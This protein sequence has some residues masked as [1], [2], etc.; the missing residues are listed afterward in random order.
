MFRNLLLGTILLAGIIAAPGTAQSLVPID[1][2][3]VTDGHVYLMENVGADLPDDSANSNNGNL[4]GSP[5][6]VAGLNGEALQ[7]NGSSDGAHLPDAATINTSTHQNKTVIAVFNCADVGK[8][9]QQMVYEEG[10]STRGLNI[11]VHEGL[12][13][14]G[15]WNR[16]DYTPNFLGTWLSA[17]IGSNEW[18]VVAA[19]VRGGGAGLEDDKFEMWLDGEL[20]A[21]GPAGELRSR[22]DDNAIGNVQAQTRVDD[23]LVLNAGYWFEGIIDEV[24]ILN[25]ALSESELAAIGFAKTIAQNPVPADEAVDIPR[26]DELA[27]DPGEFARTHDVYLGTTFDD[28]NAADRANPMDLLVSQGQTGT[29]FDPGRLEFGQ[30]YYWRVDE[31]NAAPDNT[32]YTGDVWSFE[33]EPLAY[34]I[35][36][37]TATSTGVSDPDTGPENMVN[38][39]GLNAAGEHSIEASDMWLTVPG[40]APPALQFDFD[41]VYKLHEMRVWNYNVQFELMLGFGVKDVTIEYS[42]NG[43][44]WNVLGDF[45][46]AQGTTMPNYT[47]NTAIDFGGAAVRHVKLTVN[48]GWGPLGQ[49]GLSEVRF[50]YIPVQARE[51]QPAD[52]RTGVA[53]GTTLDWRAGREAEVHEV[54]LSSSGEAVADGT[55]LAD[56][57]SDSAY[58][59]TDLEFGTDYYWRIVEVNEAEAITAWASDIWMFRTEEFAFIEGFESYDDDENRIYDT[60]LDGWINETGSTVGYLE[61]PFA[62]TTIVHSGSQSMPLQYDNSAAPFYSEAEYDLGGMNLNGNG[63]DTLRLF[64]SGQAPAFLETA[65]GSILM[66]AIGTDIWGTADEF[67]FAYRTLNGNGSLTARV[68]DRDASSDPWMKAGVM[69]RQGTDA[70][71][72]NTYMA[73]TG[74]N[75]NGATYQQRMDADTASVSQHTYDDGPFAPPYWV[76][77]TREGDTLLGYT[78]PDGENWTQRGEVVTLAMTD[79]VLIGLALTSHNASQATSAEFSQVTFTG[80]VTG[81]WEVAEIG[82]A[83]PTGNEPTPLYVAL[84]DSAGNVA[85]V[86]DP[87]AAVRSGWTEW[88]I[89]YSDLTAIN[90]NT[91][92]T[93][94]IGLGDRDNPTAG[95]AGII[96]VDDIGY[97]SPYTGPADITAAGDVVQGVPNDGDWPGAETPELSIDDDVNTKYLHFK[98]DFDP[99][100]GPTGLQITPA[101][102][103]TVVTG[104]TFTTANDVPGRDPIAFELYGSDE[105]IDGPYTPI[106]SGDI[107]D[108]AGE[109]EWPR[110]TQTAT[111]ITFENL[112]AYEHYQLLFTAIRGPVGGSVN[113]MQIAEIELI[114]V[115]A[116]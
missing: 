95:G 14:A 81:T 104:L 13:W 103:A 70:G 77:V 105:S 9:E 2:A 6:T 5:Q 59:P 66:N 4:L 89:P 1:P 60:W 19:V 12:A 74:G 22:S 106:A 35:P 57:V 61:E 51:A 108:F 42:E 36:N 23:E 71:A 52:G 24:W 68:D 113:S 87:D 69:I 55:A 10:G 72:I 97:G 82:V 37:V 17:P 93:M 32:I 111:M 40:G 98:G 41:Q 84:E 3:T 88:L 96:F 8:A 47:A 46:L 50:M 15:A 85:V 90:L 54:Y 115:I 80:N 65:D 34:P 67:R 79:P 94:Y 114:G 16:G 116:P 110:F 18:H 33:V 102:G 31:V 56:A 62:E 86:S 20:V 29:T 101:A 92:Q 91:V 76:R 45:E 78:S 58:T 44:D 49:F 21:K 39:S 27:W 75:G 107:A 48:S 28:V 25:Q 11:Y 100:A 43:A 30:T 26:D 38:D 63:A 112:M 83:Q 7:L 73:I 99:D 53:V 64:V 109:T